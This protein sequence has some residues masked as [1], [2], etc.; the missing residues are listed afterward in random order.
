MSKYKLSNQQLAIKQALAFCVDL[1][2]VSLPLL[3]APSLEIL[4][5]F[6][7]LWYLYIP[8]MEYYKSQTFGMMLIGTRIV[9]SNDKES[10]IALGT[11]FRRQLARVSM[12]W[13]VLGWLFLFFSKQYIADYVISD[14]KN[15]SIE[16]NAEGLVRAHKNNQYKVIFLAFA[17]MAL[18]SIAKKSF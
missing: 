10:R 1:A 5:L 11:A 18:F 13:G 15:Y 6:A 3:I 16:S 4:P 2:L 7:L 12:M 14:G 8:L 17:I 9:N